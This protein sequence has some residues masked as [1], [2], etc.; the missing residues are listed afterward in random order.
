MP[1][2]D[3]SHTPWNKRNNEWI[4]LGPHSGPLA[5]YS[6]MAELELHCRQK[7]VYYKYYTSKTQPYI[8]NKALYSEYASKAYGLYGYSL[9]LEDYWEITEEALDV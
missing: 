9:R 4:T 1:Y 7:Q 8:I 5:L 3:R 6:K 2:F